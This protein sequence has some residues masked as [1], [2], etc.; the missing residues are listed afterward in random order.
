VAER[1]VNALPLG[2]FSFLSLTCTICA[3]AVDFA[4][5]VCKERKYLQQFW[6]FLQITHLSPVL[7][8]SCLLATV[9]MVADACNYSSAVICL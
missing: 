4:Q 5:S 1:Y 8:L 3:Q 2:G 9:G 7:L 6:N